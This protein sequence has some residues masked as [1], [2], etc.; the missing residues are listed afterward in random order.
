[1]RPQ[2][3]AVASLALCT[4]LATVT[5]HGAGAGASSSHTADLNSVDGGFTPKQSV[6]GMITT[7]PVALLAEQ[8]MF[9]FTRG[10]FTVK[11]IGADHSPEGDA[12]FVVRGKLLSLHNPMLIMDQAGK[13]VA[14]VQ[15]YL[16]AAHP[17]YM[18]YTYS[19][20]ERGQASEETDDDGVP[21]YRFAEVQRA[22]LALTPEFYYTLYAGSEKRR[23]SA[24]LAKVQ[25]S[26]AGMFNLQMDIREP[27][28][29]GP[30]LGTVGKSTIFH[31][32]RDSRWMI[33][34]GKG[35]DVLGVLCLTIAA[36]AI[37][38]ESKQ[39]H[40][41]CFGADASVRLPNGTTARIDTVTGSSG[42][43]TK[44][45]HP[46]RLALSRWMCWRRLNWG[47]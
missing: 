2:T 14:L 24:L 21:M 39:S 32:P 41:G 16:M 9:S 10:D 45:C 22:L 47:V 23:S 44:P 29:D 38:E 34:V 12:V 1:M 19:P 5:I 33:E 43:Q 15:K 25:A 11:A 4:V 35:M 8:K 31:L 37:I 28:T 13:K 26:F 17:T 42:P 18:I 40:G 3:C 6:N 27:G 36:N 30:I 20:N 46:P 7:A